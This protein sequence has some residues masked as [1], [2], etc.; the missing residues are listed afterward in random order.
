MLTCS[1]S[2]LVRNVGKSNVQKMHI[3][4]F[5][6]TENSYPEIPDSSKNGGDERLYI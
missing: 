5:Q 3:A 4:C 2:E 6:I 1:K